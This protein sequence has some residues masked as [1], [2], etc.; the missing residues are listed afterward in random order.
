MNFI[1]H[2]K[3][4]KKLLYTLGGKPY[5]GCYVYSRDQNDKTH[6]IG[7]SQAG[8]FRRLKQAKSCYPYKSEF[9]LEYVIISLDGQYTKGKKSN[10]IF[11]ENALHTESKHMSTVKIQEDTEKEQGQRPKEYRML[12]SNTQMYNLLKKTLNTHR[13]KWDYVVVFSTNGWHILS[14]D[15][16]VDVPITANKQIKP[17]KDAT[18]SPVIDSLPLNKTKLILPKNIKPGDVVEKSDNWGKFVVVEVISK[19][20]IVAKFPPSK[21][22]YHIYIK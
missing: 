2:E 18:K 7:M 21:K 13:D 1:K 3:D 22:E 9:W 10:T 20:H 14:N 12:S 6:K 19:K 4:I 17:T 16:I 8:L 15:R 11:I 5:S